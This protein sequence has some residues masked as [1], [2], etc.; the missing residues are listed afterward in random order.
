MK[1]CNAVLW[2]ATL[3]A[4]AVIADDG[5][6]RT[7]TP[8]PD[9]PNCVSTQATT[10]RARMAPIAFTGSADAAQAALRRAIL[11]LPRSTITREEPGFI[12][13]EFR[14][15]IF[16]FVDAAEFSIDATASVIHFRSGARTGYS[17]MGVN[18]ARM[19]ELAKGIAA[20]RP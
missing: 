8:C 12:A 18:R 5:T 2:L 4:P 9:R 7:L 11:A 16:G 3:A 20:A 17:D 6:P 14:S 19:E 10:D 15:R 13:A 1:I